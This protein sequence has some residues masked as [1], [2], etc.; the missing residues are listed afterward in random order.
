MRAA[1]TS[2][3]RVQPCLQRRGLRNLEA[4]LP[5]EALEDFDAAI[6]LDPALPEAWHLRAQAYERGGD[7]T[8]AAR[9][10]QEVLR[11]EPPAVITEEQIDQVIAALREA[12]G[13]TRELLAM[14][15]A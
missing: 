15:N 1:Q 2:A 8:A 14:L 13:H 3:V 10:L 6:T 4:R 5:E 12:F 7:L 9:D 11:L